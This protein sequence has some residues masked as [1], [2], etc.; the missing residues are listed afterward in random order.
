LNRG[1]KLF[2]NSVDYW[3][4]LVKLLYDYHPRG[5]QTEKSMD[6][7]IHRFPQDAGARTLRADW[8]CNKFDYTLCREEVTAAMS[9]APDNLLRIRLLT[10]SATI[11]DSQGNPETAD[12]LFAESY[13]LNL[14]MQLPDQ[15]SAVAYIEF[16]ERAQQDVDAQKHV[17]EILKLAPGLGSAHFSRAKYL[18]KTGRYPEAIGEAN[19]AMVAAGE[20]PNLLQSV[21]AFMARTYFAMG[22]NAEAEKH[23]KWIEQNVTK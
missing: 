8:A 1:L 9:L 18:F 4:G 10:L 21:H 12:K 6:D 17:D 3:R 16:L 22:K 20:N 11:E 15:K 14:K 23:Q 7:L 2:S 19:L 5:P 13:Q